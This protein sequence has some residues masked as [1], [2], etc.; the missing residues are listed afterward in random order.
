MTKRPGRWWR[1]RH[2]VA[3]RQGAMGNR[4]LLKPRTGVE[5]GTT[6]PDALCCSIDRGGTPLLASRLFLGLEALTELARVPRP[7]R[8]LIV[9]VPNVP[10][11][12]RPLDLALL[13]RWHSVGDNHS[14][15]LP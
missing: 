11:W 5:I 9:A 12:C 2:D 3:V 13:G 7:C 1:V 8:A 4:F 15:S 10:H 6:R 14:V